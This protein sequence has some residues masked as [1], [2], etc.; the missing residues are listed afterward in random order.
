MKIIENV[1]NSQLS[2]ARYYGGLNL[3]GIEYIYEAK[4]DRLIRNDY[5][6]EYN[7]LNKPIK[8]KK[9]IKENNQL[10]IFD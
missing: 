1:S 7:K 5:L 3:N 6:K 4:T 10:N 9:E 2:I 8:V